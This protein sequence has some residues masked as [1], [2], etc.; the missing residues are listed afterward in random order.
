MK[1]ALLADVHANAEA[2]LAVLGALEAEHVDEIVCLGDVVGYGAS[3]NE[4]V[5]L[6]AHAGATSVAGNHDR[7]AL[8]LRDMD[9]FG[10]AARRSMAWTK[11]ALGAEAH[12]WLSTLPLARRVGRDLLLFH[13][14]LHPTLNDELHLST[15]PRLERSLEVL[16]A[17]GRGA[18]IGLF[19]HTH[20]PGVWRA[21]SGAFGP[22]PGEQVALDEGA[23]YLV[24]PGSVGQ[25]RDVDPRAAFA[26]LDTNA[27]MVRFRRVEYDL[28]L[29]R[30][31]VAAAEAGEKP[32]VFAW[33]SARL[34]RRLFTG[35]GR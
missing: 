10:R 23:Y 17:G 11:R 8:G 12:E 27:G 28:T 29:S 25:S 22:A 1:Y 26:V 15:L 2:L 5:R 35:Q 30:A 6:L 19:G 18:R 20:H 7:A 13:A 21:R 33:L 31:K 9:S 16:A 14:A 32:R 24:N 4:C 3:P 34:A